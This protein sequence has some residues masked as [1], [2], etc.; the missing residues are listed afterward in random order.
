M[1]VCADVN[2]IGHLERLNLHE[3]KGGFVL[4]FQV[5]QFESDRVTRIC[6]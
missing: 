6:L 3:D 5:R 2:E 1:C 4:F